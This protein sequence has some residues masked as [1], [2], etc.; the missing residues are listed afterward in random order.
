MDLRAD[1]WSL[2]ALGQFWMAT[3]LHNLGRLCA[4][5]MV[6]AICS[7]ADGQPAT[8]SRFETGRKLMVDEA[9]VGGGVTDPRV[10]AAMREVPRHEFVPSRQ[11]RNAYFDM[12]LPI[13]GGQ[14]ISPPYIVS[15]MTERLEPRPTD[16]VLEIGT[17]SGYQAAVLSSL[18][19]DVYTIEIVESLGRKAAQTLRRLGYKNV[20]PKVG[21]G[22]QGWPEH[23]PFDK[24]IVTCSPE[25]IPVPLVEQLAEG[26]RMVIPLGERFQQSLYLF[27]KVEGKLERESLEAT[28]FVPM[29]GKAE[30]ERQQQINEAVPQL[31]HASF[32][33]TLDDSLLPRGWFYVRQAQVTDQY[34]ATDGQTAVAL[35][36]S[37]SGRPSGIMQAFGVDGR[38]VA[39]I[40]LQLDVRGTDLGQGRSSAE[41]PGVMLEFYG[42]QRSP[43][44]SRRFG[45]W[46]GT[47]DWENRKMRVAVPR[48]ARLAIIGV[49]LFGGTGTVVVDDI[50]ISVDRKRDAVEEAH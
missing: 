10:I 28:F 6:L 20:H 21:D 24:I 27:R 12:A 30:D 42:P 9:V 43:V 18:V 26:G 32:E 1:Q 41:N 34:G 35:T 3:F 22:Y 25:D 31:R 5:T 33:E 8:S 36:N 7:A 50:R 48:R 19:A 11:R 15:F 47:F 37:D 40:Q 2:A 49:G 23:A 4:G 29:T 16:R 39:A 46:H 45:P 13:G 38:M 14:T 44:G 17:G